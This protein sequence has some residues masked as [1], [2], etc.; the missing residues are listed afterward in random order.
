[1]TVDMTMCNGNAI[2][3]C[4]VYIFFGW[5]IELTEKDNPKIIG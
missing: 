2:I 5:R 4:F 3:I 1:M